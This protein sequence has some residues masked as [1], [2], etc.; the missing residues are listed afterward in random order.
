MTKVAVLGDGITAQA[1][2]SFLAHA[3]DYQDSPIQT[4]DW[5]VTS[6]GIPPAQ[7]PATSV[8]IISDI[9]FA[10][11]VLHSRGV[12]PTIV[13]ITGTNGKTTVTAGLAHA[14]NQTAYG[15]IGRPLILDIDHCQAS[16]PLIIELSSYQLVSSPSLHCDVAVILNI[17]P[18]HLAW[19]GTFEAYQAAKFSIIKGDQ[20]VYMPKKLHESHQWPHPIDFC[21]IDDLN[22]AELDQFSG[23][24]NQQNAAII[25]D[26]ATY[27]GLDHSVMMQRLKTFN[28]PP[29]RCQKL[30]SRNGRIIVNDSKATNMS[31]T[32]AAVQSFPGRKLLI[33]AGQAKAPF[34]DA[35]MRLV[36]RECEVIYAAGDLAKNKA[37]F[38]K[39]W[40]SK[41]H[42]F[43]SVASATQSALN[44]YPT[45]TI[46]FS[47][48]AASFDE[49]EN[50]VARGEA[51]SH[52]VKQHQ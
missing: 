49:F 41:L 15:N 44:E 7:W 24:H 19:H 25:I 36:F 43:D 38:P 12:F 14:L 34:S 9:E 4:A 8:E 3:N 6:P 16:D 28:L 5:I 33:L 29:F 23:A 11:R 32:I 20:R 26:I 21:A 1:V 50:Y 52:Y 48:A 2:R 13:G 17:E 46:L 30:T 10:I 45:G 42:F 27:L 39:E 18:D 31:A 47:P 40:Q 22:C 35:F 51:F 37:V